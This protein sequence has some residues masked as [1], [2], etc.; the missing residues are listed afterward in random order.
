[1]NLD[2]KYSPRATIVSCTASGLSLTFSPEMSA[3]I[4][5]ADGPSVT[6]TATTISVSV[7]PRAVPPPLLP[8]KLK[9]GGEYGSPGTCWARSAHGCTP[10]CWPACAWSPVPASVAPGAPGCVVSAT[11]SPSVSTCSA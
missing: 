8:L 11:P 5:A 4:S 2:E 6:R 10:P 7:T 3:K 9:H 1:V